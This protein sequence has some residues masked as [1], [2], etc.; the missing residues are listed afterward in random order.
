MFV[1]RQITSA[2]TTFSGNVEVKSAT[3]TGDVN[4]SKAVFKEVND[5]NARVDFGGSK[6]GGNLRLRGMEVQGSLSFGDC[7]VAGRV[8]A[9]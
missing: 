1:E 3:F 5:R 8:E 6:F 9:E 2:Q 4:L 7:D